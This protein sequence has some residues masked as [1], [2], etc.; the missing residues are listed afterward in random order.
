MKI[1]SNKCVY[2]YPYKPETIH[3]RN[4]PKDFLFYEQQTYAVFRV[5]FHCHCSNKTV[6]CKYSVEPACFEHS[7]FLYGTLCDGVEPHSS[8]IGAL[9]LSCL[10]NQKK[11]VLQCFLLRS[12]FLCQSGQ[13]LENSL[14]LEPQ[15]PYKSVPYIKK[16]VYSFQ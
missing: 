13:F 5:K 1:P 2:T 3:K 7:F 8:L 14:L 10:F 9:F 11:R 4:T 6:A 16:R 15:V 12:E